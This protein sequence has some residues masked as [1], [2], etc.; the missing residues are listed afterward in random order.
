MLTNYINLNLNIEINTKIDIEI[1]N[2]AQFIISD[3][4]KNLDNLDKTNKIKNITSTEQLLE[5]LKNTPFILINN[6]STPI[7]TITL[8]KAKEFTSKIRSFVKKYNDLDKFLSGTQI[9]C[10]KGLCVD[11]ASKKMQSRV[12]TLSKSDLLI[13]A[14][15]ANTNPAHII[16][17]TAGLG[18]D[19]FLL[20]SAYPDAKLD[21]IE[22]NPLIHKLLQSGIN[23]LSNNLSNNLKLHN[24]NSDDIIPKLE[25][26]D[27][28]YLDP[29]FADNSFKGQVKKPM[30]WLHEICPPP[31]DENLNKLCSIALKYAKKRV[32]IKRAKNAPVIK[33]DNKIDPNHQ[34]VGKSVRYD[35]YIVLEN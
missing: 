35:V 20:A 34:I 2:S 16:D 30:Q 13:K 29:M 21:L 22:E 31:S 14:V 11:F 7:N 4:F 32:I 8:T 1:N 10:E 23:N 5:L 6:N 15:G 33:I 28:I 25:P 19:S 12:E 9:W 3:N 24:K 26:A 18:T 27:V 17:A